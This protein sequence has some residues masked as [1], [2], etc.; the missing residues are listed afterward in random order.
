MAKKDGGEERRRTMKGQWLLVACAVLW[1]GSV[2][3]AD[4]FEGVEYISGKAGFEKKVK[5]QLTIDEKEVRF[6]DN[7]G[8][9]VFSIPTAEIEKASAGTQH[10]SG[11]FGR[12]MALGIFASKT[13]EYLTVESHNADGA[14]GVVFKVK[15]KT[16]AGMATKISYWAGKGR[17]RATEA[18]LSPPTAELPPPRR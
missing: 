17:A 10:D 18:P 6:A 16:G 13:E 14:E 7:Q 8:K 1:A 11:S 4:T 12:K 9:L 15:K 3:A 2:R 5:G